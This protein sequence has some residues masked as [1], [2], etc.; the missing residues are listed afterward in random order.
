MGF[1]TT[2]FKGAVISYLNKQASSSL[3]SAI[4]CAIRGWGDRVPEDLLDAWAKEWW[5]KRQAPAATRTKA[6]KV[7]PTR[8]ITL[9]DL[10]V[11]DEFDYLLKRLNLRTDDVQSVIRCVTTLGGLESAMLIVEE[12]RKLRKKGHSSE[13]SLF[14]GGGLSDLEDVSEDEGIGS[15]Y[16]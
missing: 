5:S 4:A 11:A 16:R 1:K 3:A 9:R 7:A 15:L 6:R 13:P 14:D 12:L 8:E 10:K 2:Q